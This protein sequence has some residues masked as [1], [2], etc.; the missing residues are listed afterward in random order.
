MNPF[1]IN[2]IIPDRYFCDRKAET[3]KIET[4]ITNQ[5]NLLMTSPRRMGKT[6]LIHHVYNQK[7]IVET[8]YTFYVDI[9]STTSLHEFVL[10]LSKEIYS[11]LVPKGRKLL[12]SFISVLK[13]LSG[14]FGYDA[15]TGLPSFDVRLGDILMPE[16]TLSEIFSYLENADRPCVFT[17][18]EFQQ[19]G[20][21]SEKNVE[22]LL[23][24]HIQKMNNCRFIFAG[25]DR[26]TLENMFNSPAKPFYNSVEQ[27]YLARIDKDI[28]TGFVREIFREY[29]RQISDQALSYVYDLFEGH[30]YYVH[31]TLH[32]AFAYNGPEVEISKETIDATVSDILQER[33]H[34]FLTQLS[35]LNYAQKE[36]LIAIA[37]DIRA[38]EITSVAFVRKHSLQSPSSVQNAVRHLLKLQMITYEMDGSTKVYSVSDRFLRMWIAEKY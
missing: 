4:C 26:H 24:T 31:N 15:L 6:Q 37:K 27:M 17:I 20:K 1:V 9:Y 10:L 19:I 35:L 38:Y 29:E 14:C 11:E 2:G 7:A 8:Y 5:T 25:S 3:R 23:R 13:S 34:S 22:A 18:D 36:T 30:T 28:Y 32:N 16:L 33:E 12:D 21:Y